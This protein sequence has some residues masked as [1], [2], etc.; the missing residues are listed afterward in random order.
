M[1]KYICMVAC[2]VLVAGFAGCKKSDKSEMSDLYTGMTGIF[3]QTAIKIEASKTGKEAG[4]VLL[5]S[6]DK[7]LEF[8]R[9]ADEF[10]KSHPDFNVANESEFKDEIMKY[11]E[12]SGKFLKAVSNA[13][14]KFAKDK[15]YQEALQKIALQMRK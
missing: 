6:S 1:R 11:K 7:M 2:T 3:E 15:D 8:S 4:D 12:A 5:S 9:K 13:G 14:V 10:A